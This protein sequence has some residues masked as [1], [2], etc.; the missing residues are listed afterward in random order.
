MTKAHKRPMAREGKEIAIGKLLPWE[1]VMSSLPNP[2]KKD[3]SW[4]SRMVE[5]L[6]T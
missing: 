6:A 5:S 3:E 4:T 2:F 1:R